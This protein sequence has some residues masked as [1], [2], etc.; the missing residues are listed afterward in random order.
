MQEEV[1]QEELS[2]EVTEKLEQNK[3]QF[4]A[5]KE[6]IRDPK[7]A[8]DAYLNQP[9]VTQNLKAWAESIEKVFGKRWF[10][11]KELAKK[12]NRSAKDLEQIMT[13]MNLKGFSM[14][15]QYGVTEQISY[16]LTLT[17]PY[18]ILC[19]EDE[20]FVLENDYQRKKDALTNE[21]ERLK[22]AVSKTDDTTA[23]S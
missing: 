13:F 14:A 21:L 4:E 3:K 12:Y 1:K 18:R 8:M 9:E 23:S 7:A 22:T 17:D 15:R 5:A 2:V 11:I 6:E 16:R 10:T 19:L 20:L